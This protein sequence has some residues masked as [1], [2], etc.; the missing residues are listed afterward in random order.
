MKPIARHPR[1]FTLMELLIVLALT[2]CLLFCGT[3]VASRLFA[4]SQEQR[5][6]SNLRQLHIGVMSYA[7]DHSGEVPVDRVS[8]SNGTNWYMALLPYV[9]HAGYG[10]KKGLYICPSNNSKGGWTNYAFNSRLYSNGTNLGLAPDGEER[11]PFLASRSAM[12]FA[13]VSGQRA[14]LLDAAGATGGTWYL[15]GGGLSD[16]TWG[17]TYAVH[18]DCVNLIFVDGH[19]RSVRVNPRTTNAQRDLNEMRTDWF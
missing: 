16:P 13:S 18:R 1:A 2:L 9:P 4:M 11:N 19:T 7:A 14:L 6:L 15:V 8:I 17:S 12:R 10:S 5:C 3:A